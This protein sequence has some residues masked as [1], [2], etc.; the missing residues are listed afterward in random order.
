MVIENLVTGNCIMQ[1]LG[2]HRNKTY[3]CKGCAQN[4]LENEGFQKNVTKIF[5][6]KCY[7]YKWKKWWFGTIMPV[8]KIQ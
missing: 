5:L 1:G 6:L 2:V 3:P 8:H 7:A 4:C